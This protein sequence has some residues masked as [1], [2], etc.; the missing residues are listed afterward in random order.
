MNSWMNE[1]REEHVNEKSLTHSKVMKYFWPINKTF[2]TTPNSNKKKLLLFI[3][4]M[5]CP[6]ECK[7]CCNHTTNKMILTSNGF[8]SF[9]PHTFPQHITFNGNSLPRQWLFPL[10]YL[11]AFCEFHI[12]RG[13]GKNAKYL[14]NL[15]FHFTRSLFHC[16]SV[17]LS[18]FPFSFI[19][20]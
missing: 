18:F 6:V 1:W 11:F 8:L 13:D 16:F 20:L 14:T 15:P 10:H 17:L 19:S 9:L 4:W 5:K 3:C 2:L 12:M 7:Q